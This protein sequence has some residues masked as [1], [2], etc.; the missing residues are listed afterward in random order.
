MAYLLALMYTG[1]TVVTECRGGR[2]DT[3]PPPFTSSICLM[4]TLSTAVLIALSI[5]GRSHRVTLPWW[6][7]VWIS[8]TLCPKNM[9]EEKEKNDFPVHDCTQ[10]QNGSLHFF[11]HR[12]EM[13]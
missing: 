5:E 6:Q 9:A 4:P 2:R 8:A 3:T 7:N 1:V 13:K 12:S 10:E 11:P